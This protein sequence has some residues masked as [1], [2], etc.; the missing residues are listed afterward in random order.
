MSHP[1]RP[2]SRTAAMQA[3]LELYT[4]HPSASMDEVAAHAGIGRATLFR[5]FSNRTALLRAAG[6]HVIDQVEA[7][8]DASASADDP[9][10]IRLRALIG[11]LVSAG[12]PLHAVFA[13]TDLAE[14]PELKS[15]LKRL[16]RA[17]EPVVI[18]CIAAG[19]LRADMPEAWFEAA[20]EGLLYAAWTAI[21]KG[22]LAP[23]H[24][25][26]MLLHTLLHGFGPGV[27]A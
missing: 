2:D 25:P 9:P 17:I 19:L 12:L 7:A 26:D 3:G 24:A 18:D 1:K 16:D 11:V 5:H 13:I 10:L 22:T 20:F 6:A 15:A 21:H 27:N 4:L 23:A 8:L 14:D